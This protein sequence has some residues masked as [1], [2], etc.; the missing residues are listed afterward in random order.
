M[1]SFA[2]TQVQPVFSGSGTCGFRGFAWRH[3][4]AQS[5]ESVKARSAAGA[6]QVS[7]QPKAQWRITCW[8]GE[9]LRASA[10]GR[11]YA[12]RLSWR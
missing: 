12:A 6:S 2:K 1:L 10:A 8:S 5:G 9:M 7:E 11:D 4:T 3:G